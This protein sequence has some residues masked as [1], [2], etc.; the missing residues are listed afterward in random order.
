M[1]TSLLWPAETPQ[2]IIFGQ[3]DGKVRNIDLRAKRLT[4]LF[5]SNS[6][7]ISL[8]ASPRGQTILSGHLDGKITSFTL[9]ESTDQV[10]IF[11]LILLN[12][13]MTF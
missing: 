4:T 13:Y 10:C 12:I 2:K 9:D 11:F 7:V 6:P 1:V 5:A 8:V 3:A